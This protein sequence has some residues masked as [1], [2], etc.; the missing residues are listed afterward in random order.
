MDQIDNV[1][2]SKGPMATSLVS[3]LVD[4]G[5]TAFSQEKPRSIY[6]YLQYQQHLAE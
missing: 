5:P 3:V 2:D 1:I 6:I 4:G